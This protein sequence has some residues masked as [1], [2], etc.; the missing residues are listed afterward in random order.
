MAQLVEALR[1]KAEGLGFDSRWC[2]W[3][4]SLTLSCRPHYGPG[5]DSASNS[6][7]NDYQ[8]IFLVLIS[9]E[10]PNSFHGHSAPGRIMSMTNSSDTIGNRTRDLPACSALPQQTSEFVATYVL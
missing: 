9:V 4:F 3:N 5:V 6:N 8:E 10:M 7:R 2:H 1:Y